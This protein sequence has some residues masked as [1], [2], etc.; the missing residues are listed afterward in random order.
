MGGCFADG[1]ICP[2]GRKDAKETKMK[3]AVLCA[4]LLCLTMVGTVQAM[5]ADDI[6]VG[7]LKPLQ[8]L[9][10]TM[11]VYD[12]KDVA[13]GAAAGIMAELRKR[14]VNVD[15]SDLSIVEGNARTERF[16]CLDG[17]ARYGSG[18]QLL[19]TTPSRSGGFEH[20]ATDVQSEVKI[21]AGGE[22]G[23]GL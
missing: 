13:E 19:M 7:Y 4:V 15:E 14:G 1:G 6:R 3:T 17:M 20:E 12:V 16:S 2:D 22:V 11:V 18:S 21:L 8:L 10:N 5:D 9:R 23:F